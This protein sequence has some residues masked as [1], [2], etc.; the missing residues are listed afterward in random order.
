MRWWEFDMTY[1]ALRLMSMVGLVHSLKL[2][3]PVVNARAPRP[4]VVRA[5]AAR[6]DDETELVGA[7]N[8]PR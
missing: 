3:K 2:P 1:I 8:R 4:G 5:E 7:V 6:T